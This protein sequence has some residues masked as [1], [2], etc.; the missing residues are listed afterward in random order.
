MAKRPDVGMAG[1]SGYDSEFYTTDYSGKV[2]PNKR[3]MK[4]QGMDPKKRIAD[5]QK[6]EQRVQ[7]RAEAGLP[8]TDRDK[9]RAKAVGGDAMSWGR[10]SPETYD[11]TT[12]Q[13]NIASRDEDLRQKAYDRGNETLDTIARQKKQFATQQRYGD[14]SFK[15]SAPLTKAMVAA[16][17]KKNK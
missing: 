1:S 3:A 8:M 4:L 12:L 6:Q 13:T 9:A 5:S 16:Y 10:F 7:A 15:Q 14:N 17:K 11:E 2:Q